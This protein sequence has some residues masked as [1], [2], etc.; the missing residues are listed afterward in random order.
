MSYGLLG[1]KLGHSFSKVLHGEM[2][3]EDY[4]LIPVSKDRVD[5]YLLA[6]DFD[7][8]NVTIPYKE[9]AMRYCIPDE[10]ASEIG[11][12]NTLFKK[13]GKVYGYN[14]DC[15]GFAYLARQVG[16]SDGSQNIWK[17]KKVVI[18]GSGGT[19]KTAT[20]VALKCGASKVVIVS[21]KIINDENTRPN[22]IPCV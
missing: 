9:T 4:E 1:E 6:A 20:Y 10:I 2:G 17:D 12:V 18:L 21:R 15:L 8:I 7:G 13:N 16:S 19:S 5:D 14:T 11:C 3:N 22:V